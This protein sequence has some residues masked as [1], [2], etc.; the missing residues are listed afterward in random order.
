MPTPPEAKSPAPAVTR[1]AAILSLIAQEGRP[2]GL[3]DIARRLDLA[4]SSTL[5]LCI[6]LEQTGLLTRTELGY[7]L[8]RATVE[9]GGAYVR[10]FDLIREFYRVCAASPVLQ[11]EL[12]QIAILDGT[13][14]LYLA[15]HEGRAPLRLSATVGDRFPATVTAVGAALLAE[16]D[17][18]E[19]AARFADPSTLPSWTAHS[20]HTVEGLLA[21]LADTRD[22]GYAVDEG[23]TNAGVY[24]VAVVLP[25]RRSGDEPLAL[26]ASL[27]KPS[28]T[29]E[30]VRT[31]VAALREAKEQLTSPSL[32][33]D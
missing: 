30:Y 32:V 6:A 26:G 3:A 12:L 2:L 15:R 19:V 20:T 21:K 9:L 16:I 8:G 31:V 1:A 22:R 29:P 10:G 5:N 17:P 4:K 23:E 25:P 18:A 13:S 33:V 28:A 24:G 14:V 7:G 11:H 27:M